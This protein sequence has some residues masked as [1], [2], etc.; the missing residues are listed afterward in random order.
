MKTNQFGVAEPSNAATLLET[1]PPTDLLRQ[2]GCGP[3]TFTGDDLALYERHMTF[4]RV[5]PIAKASARDKFEAAAHSVRDVLSQRWIKTEETYQ[6]RNAKR[7]YYLSME[8]LL[9]RMLAN[10]VTNLRLA[11]I[12]AELQNIK[13]IDPLEIAEQEPDPGLGN[14]GLGRLA[15]CFLDSMAH[16]PSRERVMACVMNTAFSGKFFVTGGKANNLIIGWLG[17]IHGRS[18]GPTKRLR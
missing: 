10:N 1:P 18:P 3:V 6:E 16:S 8:F 7:V 17:R 13:G 11:P 14:G 12:L 2:Y 4:D 5:A 15:A 9:G